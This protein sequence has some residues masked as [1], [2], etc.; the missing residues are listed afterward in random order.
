[1]QLFL[2]PSDEGA[3]FCEAKD[4]G[5]E[6]SILASLPPALRATS[7]IRGRLTAAAELGIAKAFENPSRA[8]EFFC[9][10]DRA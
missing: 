1:M 8:E 6:I 10:K 7:L 5:R 4:W 9:K 2:A 3:G